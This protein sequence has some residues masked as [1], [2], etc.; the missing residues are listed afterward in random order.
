MDKKELSKLYDYLRISQELRDTYG[1]DGLHGEPVTKDCL[2]N[3]QTFFSIISPQI[4]LKSIQF[5]EDISGH[6]RGGLNLEWQRIVT[7]GNKNYIDFMALTFLGDDM[8][9]LESDLEYLGLKSKETF[10]I[11]SENN[12]CARLYITTSVNI[13]KIILIMPGK[14]N[15]SPNIRKKGHPGEYLP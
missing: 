13:A 11:L 6:H 1:W 9:R 10:A 5:P 14:P 12:S 4:G 3:I 15:N 8:V 7:E 2:C